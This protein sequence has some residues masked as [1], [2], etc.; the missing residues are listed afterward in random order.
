MNVDTDGASSDCI[1]SRSSTS[2]SSGIR[3]HAGWPDELPQLRLEAALEFAAQRQQRRLPLPAV[4]DIL[5]A[6]V[7]QLVT[8]IEGEMKILGSDRPEIRPSGCGGLR[9]PSE[10]RFADRTP[11]LW[12]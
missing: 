11:R 9:K 3:W 10:Q 12:K 4:I 8:A 2:I 5:E 6:A 7:V 1:N